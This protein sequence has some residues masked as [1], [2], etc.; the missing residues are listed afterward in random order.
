M[1]HMKKKMPVFF[2]NSPKGV[3]KPPKAK[4]KK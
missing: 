2:A 4:K 1:T 3:A